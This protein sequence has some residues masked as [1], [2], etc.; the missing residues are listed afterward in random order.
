MRVIDYAT[1]ASFISTFAFLIL[2]DVTLLSRFL[3]SSFLLD[4]VGFMPTGVCLD[5]IPCEISLFRW[6]SV[7]VRKCNKVQ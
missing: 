2:K 4:K 6:M 1:S 3:F 7:H 5:F